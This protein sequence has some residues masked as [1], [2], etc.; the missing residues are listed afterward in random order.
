[1][2]HFRLNSLYDWRIHRLTLKVCSWGLLL[3]VIFLALVCIPLNRPLLHWTRLDASIYLSL[4]WCS[5]FRTM[6]LIP[7]ILD[8]F[9]SLDLFKLRLLSIQ[10]RC[11][12]A[13][14]GSFH[15]FWHLWVLAMRWRIL[16]H[17]RFHIILV[18]RRGCYRYDGLRW[19]D[20]CSIAPEILMIVVWRLLKRRLLY[21]QWV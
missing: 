15:L 16:M 6:S 21:R 4:H 8:W 18:N 10:S 19:F 5:K 17:S 7:R 13:V 2:R 20:A 9:K 3:K 11:Q 1:M 14:H 12:K